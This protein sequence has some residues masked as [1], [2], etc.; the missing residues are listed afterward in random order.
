MSGATAVDYC[1]MLIRVIE[2]GVKSVVSAS[3][4]TSNFDHEVQQN[5][6]DAAALTS[7][8]S[9]VLHDHRLQCKR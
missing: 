3:I 5:V 6:T 8:D 4:E 1:F 9:T 2:A 7:Q